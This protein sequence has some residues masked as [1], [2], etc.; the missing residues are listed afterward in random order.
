MHVF[1]AQILG[2]FILRMIDAIFISIGLLY[3]TI[4]PGFVVTELVVPKF[5]F[6]KKIPL[7]LLLSVIVS[8][9]FTYVAALIFG[10]DRATILSC[11][12]VFFVPF[13]YLLSKR[14]GTFL[15][16]IK[17]NWVVLSAGF[18][19]YAI[20]F[21][22]LYPS[23]FMPYGGYIVMGG[24][25]WQDTA[26]HQSIIETLAQGNFPPQAPYFSGA[27]LSYYYFADFHASI[28]NTVYDRVFPRVLVLL[29]PFLASTFFF[30]VFALSYQLSKKKIFSILSGFMAVL[31]GNLGFGLLIEDLM[32]RKDTFINL[33]TEYAYHLDGNFLK[34]I[35][36]ADYFLQNR[37]MMVGLPAFITVIVLLLSLRKA[38]KNKTGII[39]LAGAIVGAL[40]KFQLFGFAISWL[41]FAVFT[42]LEILQRK[43]SIK[44]FLKY[45]VYFSLP[46][47]ILFLLFATTKIEQRSIFDVFAE[48]FRWG[49]WQEHSVWWFLAFVIINLNLGF[50]VF[51]TG[52]F[53]RRVWDNRDLLPIFVMAVILAVIPF[54]MT[55]TIY[56]Y[57]MFK[58]F[59]YL[60]PCISVIAA[61]LFA[62]AKHKKI[63]I[64]IF[65]AVL[66]ITSI[67]S[68]N[69]LLHAHYNKG[70]G[71]GYAEYMAGLWIRHNSP[72]KSVFVTMPTVH[73]APTDIGG[74]LRVISYINWP[75]SHGFNTGDDNVFSRVAD[76]EHVYET[77]D[78]G[79]VRLKYGARYVYYGEEEKSDF[80][81]SAELFDNNKDLKKIYNLD[82]ID[83]YEIL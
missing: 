75:H 36:M 38:G 45:M 35:P 31:Y 51:L 73:S 10:F 4:V 83:I 59:Y 29:N 39:I 64:V 22:A 60:V 81:D 53:L 56:E 8:C 71:Y 61:Y 12:A 76:V 77:G 20:H 17:K 33:I 47:L 40:V 58:F 15:Y 80:P 65:S 66:L 32:L 26:M 78:I 30:A 9:Y 63:A 5:K 19:I 23:V 3:V 43:L 72:Q 62:T 2:G 50:V 70:R 57:D 46:S 44:N 1:T 16:G 37:P 54:L 67:T 18:F 42:G 69:M 14:L 68:V 48:T 24:P 49:P 28:V 41:F 34:M 11:F 27:P 7:Y 82:R 13:V 6:W 55:F 21:V 52:I 25:N 79:S 74:R